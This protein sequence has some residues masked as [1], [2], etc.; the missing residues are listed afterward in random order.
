MT[1]IKKIIA[2]AVTAVSIGAM[3]TSAFAV[4]NWGDEF[5]LE[6]QAYEENVFTGPAVKLDSFAN[7]AAVTVHHGASSIKP[8]EFSV[9]DSED[10]LY[11]YRLTTN[12]KVR[13]NNLS[14]KMKYDSE[15]DPGKYDRFYLH[16]YSAYDMNIDGIWAP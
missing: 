3:G 11:G 9:W 10:E 15:G 4:V 7:D 12:V 16:A 14:G 8:V 6:F 13:A 1:K 2:S 5:A